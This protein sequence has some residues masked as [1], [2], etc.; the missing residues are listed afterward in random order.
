MSNFGENL[1]KEPLLFR[2]KLLYLLVDVLSGESELLVEHFVGSRETETLQ[3][4]DTAVGPD[5]C[6]T[7][8]G[9]RQSGCQ[10]ELLHVTRQHIVLI[11]YGLAPE[12]TF[13]RRAYDPYAD[14]ILAQ[15][16]GTGFER[17]NL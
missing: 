5:A 7:F 1:E 16:F 17:G 12:E 11:A 10:P 6:E 3:A 14:A 8:K 4:K 13:R 15:Q 2:D 9:A